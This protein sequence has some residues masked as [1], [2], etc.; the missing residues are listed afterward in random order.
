MT[1]RFVP[2]RRNRPHLTPGITL[3]QLYVVG[4]PVPNDAAMPDTNAAIKAGGLLVDPDPAPKV[5]DALIAWRACETK[6]DRC[7]RQPWACVSD[8]ISTEFAQNITLDDR[9]VT[10]DKIDQLMRSLS[11]PR[12]IP[13]QDLWA[14]RA[15]NSLLRTAD[16]V[17][18]LGRY[19]QRLNGEVLFL[20]YDFSDRTHRRNK[21]LHTELS[22]RTFQYFHNGRGRTLAH[23]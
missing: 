1:A 9:R 14:K 10:R 23:E 21:C 15:D 7:G 2:G 13:I 16:L 19:R 3:G 17:C 20:S 6:P 11:D 4:L 5:N 12:G 8:T 22:Q 18:I